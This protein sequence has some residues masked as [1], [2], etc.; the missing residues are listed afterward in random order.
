MAAIDKDT[1]DVIRRTVETRTA[2]RREFM[3]YAGLGIGATALPSLFAACGGGGGSSSGGGGGGASSLFFAQQSESSPLDP[4]TS[5]GEVT[6]T[7]NTVMYDRLINRDLTKAYDQPSPPIIPV[8]AESFEGSPDAKTF[9][10]KL[11]DGVTFHDG[12]PLDA[13]AVKW[14]IERM[15]VKDAP[16]YYDKAGAVTAFLWQHLDGVETPDDRTV[17]LHLSRSFAELPSM[18]C[19]STGNPAMI[20]PAQVKKVGNDKFGDQPVGTGPYKF[21]SRKRGDSIR[22]ERNT[23]PWQGGRTAASDTLVFRPIPDLSARVNALRS[24]AVH[25]MNFPSPDVLKQFSDSGDF[26]V[27]KGLTPAMVYLAFNM[28]EKPFQDVRVRRAI[29][30]AIDR[31]GIAKDLYGGTT[32]A[33]QQVVSPTSGTAAEGV[34]GYPY[35]PERAKSLLA[36]AGYGDGFSMVYESNDVNFEPASSAVVE[37]LGR[38]GIKVKMV[39]M[40]WLTYFGRW[41]EGMKPGV[42]MNVMSWGMNSPWWLNHVFVNFNSGHIED[43]EIVGLL[44]RADGEMDEAARLK[45]YQQVSALAVE[46]AYHAPLFTDTLPVITRKEFKNFVHANNWWFDYST[47]SVA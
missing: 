41:A 35:D 28:R 47:V 40:E 33:W 25:G 46:R 8:L 45:I 26:V 13:A 39:S 16:H 32:S 14:N 38:V 19:E 6:E 22:F 30:H 12:T 10:F 7:V 1:L 2:N 29:N 24:G 23:T 3:R 11:R 20:S 31:E 44:K 18:M 43:K 9:T 34:E 27:H 36:E 5:V 4:H 15:G 42:G 37:Q 17:V 21:V